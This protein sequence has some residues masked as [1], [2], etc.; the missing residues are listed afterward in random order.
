[1]GHVALWGMSSM[2]HIAFGACCLMGHI[3]FEAC[4]LMGHIVLGHNVLGYNV[5][6]ACRL[7]GLSSWGISSW[8]MVSWGMSSALENFHASEMH[9]I[10]YIIDI[11]SG[12]LLCQIKCFHVLSPTQTGVWCLVCVLLQIIKL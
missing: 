9:V 2:G 5:H 12:D 11:T 7:G 6:G 10:S 4:R 1:M 8:G 3:V